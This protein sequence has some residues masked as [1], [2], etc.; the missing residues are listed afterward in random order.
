MC[1][2]SRSQC[3]QRSAVH[4]RCRSEGPITVLVLPFFHYCYYC[5]LILSLLL[6]LLLYYYFKV[7]LL[8]S[9]LQLLLLLL[10]QL[11]SWPVSSLWRDGSSVVAA[12][13]LPLKLAWLCE[14]SSL[15]LNKAICSAFLRTPGLATPSPGI[16]WPLHKRILVPTQRPQL[17]GQAS[18]RLPSSGASLPDL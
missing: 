9:L 6:L 13:L 18:G 11:L 12:W 15:S 17:C 14:N 10:V 8:F 16:P 7:L 3:L 2:W 5:K 4:K 1:Y